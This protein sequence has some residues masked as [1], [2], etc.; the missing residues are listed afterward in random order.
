LT[1]RNLLLKIVKNCNIFLSQ[2]HNIVSK[3]ILCDMGLIINNDQNSKVLSAVST[4]KT[5][6]YV[7]CIYREVTSQLNDVP[8][9]S[10]DTVEAA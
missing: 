7:Q 6:T 8:L 2:Y 5:P 4:S 10:K 3:N 9:T 1:D